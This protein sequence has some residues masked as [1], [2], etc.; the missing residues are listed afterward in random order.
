MTMNTQL[1]RTTAISVVAV[2]AIAAA[3]RLASRLPQRLADG[4]KSSW[5]D[6]AHTALGRQINA[7]AARH[8]GLSGVHLLADAHDAFAARMLLL[9][10]AERSVD[11]QY[12]IWH[13]DRTGTLMLEAVYKAAERGVHVRLLLDDNGI[14]GLDP[15]L[16]ALDS[17]PNVEIR[18]FNPFR[19]RFPKALGFVTDFG[20]LN[21]RMHNKSFTV[22][23]AVTI[24]GGRNIGDEYF[25]AQDGGLFADLDVMAIGAVV[26]HVVR[27]FERYWTCASAYPAWQILPRASI[28]VIRRLV[29]RASIV[30]QDPWARAFV[31]RL[32]T[33]PIIRDL[34]EGDID[35][36]WCPV[37]MLSDDPAKAL[38]IADDN[39]LLAGKLEAV[40]GQPER[41]LGI[42]AGYFVPGE[43]GTRT[44]ADLSRRGIAVSV[45]TNAY[46]ANDVAMVHAGYAPARMPLLKAGVSLFEL[47]G[48]AGLPS[49]RDRR[50]G[51]RLGIGS[52]L[53]GSGTGSSA[54]LRSHA[55]TLH[56]KT[57]TVDR[58]RLFIGSF[59]F[60][61]R[62]FDLNT[63]MGFVIDSPELAGLAADTLARD[64]PARAYRLS[65]S[66]NGAINWIEHAAERS[67]THVRE[68]GMRFIDHA[69]VGLG[70]MLP[71]QWLL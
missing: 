67:I 11:L 40:I 2:A 62:S 43:R 54:A 50:R 25:G 68:P 59:N 70:R 23:G 39:G 33:L 34:M 24:V 21:R 14:S 45:L 27:D 69:I 56:A 61:P 60:D 52:K 7:R 15:V 26:P 5:E 12:Y 30:E 10:H 44:L 37:R 65:L 1:F 64:V 29:T 57:F 66:E 3:L 6:S 9:K 48:D 51:A 71:I 58:T 18:L 49:K 55:S 8:P 35:L 46:A 16:S 63:E 42:I 17:H 20:R 53:R 38:G 36:I 41:E 19:I 28:R 31:E 4:L 13:G 47:C 32:A 22:D